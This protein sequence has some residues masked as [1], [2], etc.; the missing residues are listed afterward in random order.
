MNMPSNQTPNYRLSQW[1]RT[2]RVLMEDFN[3]DNAK[4]D[5][6][7]KAE[8]EARAAL[9]RT[10]SGHAAALDQKGNCRIWSTTYTGNGS[11]GAS[12]ARRITFPGP[13]ALAIVACSGGPVMWLTPGC[14]GC[15]VLGLHSS[16][17]YIY[18]SWSGNTVFW[19]VNSGT[20]EQQFNQSGTQYHVFAFIPA[21]A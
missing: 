13:P 5:G 1:E 14:T 18:V 8:A 11:V 20:A 3:A 17:V 9:A 19:Y 21:D 10:V 6:A 15:S 2:D 12:G 7:L 4:I 16:G